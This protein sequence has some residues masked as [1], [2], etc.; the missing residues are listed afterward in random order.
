MHSTFK[1]LHIIQSWGAVSYTHLDVYKRQKLYNFDYIANINYWSKLIYR[2][3]FKITSK[4]YVLLQTN[5]VKQNE[6]KVS[7]INYKGYI[8]SYWHSLFYFSECHKLSESASCTP[9]DQSYLSLHATELK[10]FIQ[11]VKYLFSHWKYGWKKRYFCLLYT[12]RCV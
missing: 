10:L 9:R 3:N 5:L 7:K 12:S 11:L 1:Y 4:I 2:N 6:C 8:H